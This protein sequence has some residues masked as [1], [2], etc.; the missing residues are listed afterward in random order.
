MTKKSAL[1][2]GRPRREDVEAIDRRLADAALSMVLRHGSAVT[3][4][5]IVEASG[6]SRK[7]VYARHANKSA[8][9]IAVIRHLL[10]FDQEPLA[11]APSSNWKDSLRQF[12]ADSLREICQP[13]GVALRQLLML[14]P[15]YIAEVR[16]QIEMIVVRRYMD[17]LMLLL[18]QLIQDGKIP[19]HDVG[20]STEA[21]TNL[22]LAES[23]KRFFLQGDG[24]DEAALDDHA[25]YLTDFFCHGVMGQQQ[26]GT[27]AS[28]AR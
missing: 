7:T 10:D 15:A 6:L 4:N 24:D 2:R 25:R 19:P 14:D 18:G 20:R 22:I 17:P 26:D 13:E 23:H 9:L 5:A 3:M 8:L 11:I 12:V 28:S 1:P 21:L 16:T 27:T